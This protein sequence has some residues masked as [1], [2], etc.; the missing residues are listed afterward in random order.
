MSVDTANAFL[1]REKDIVLVSCVKSNSKNIDFVAE[2]LNVTL[3]RARESLFIIGQLRCLI[4]ND[5]FQDLIFDAEKRQ[6]IHR[7]SS[8]MNRSL[9]HMLLLPS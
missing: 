8:V 5:I 9:L 2:Q 4:S 1:G 7:V 6:V 3:T